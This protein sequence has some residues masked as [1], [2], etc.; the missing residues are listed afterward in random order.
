MPLMLVISCHPAIDTFETNL[1]KIITQFL[2]GL[3]PLFHTSCRVESTAS[4][5]DKLEVSADLTTLVPDILFS[6]I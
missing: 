4:S 5:V 1:S 2:G 3:G 6:N